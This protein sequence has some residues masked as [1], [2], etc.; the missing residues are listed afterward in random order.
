[1][2]SCMPNT[3]AANQ[4][5]PWLVVLIFNKKFGLKSGTGSGVHWG[6]ENKPGCCDPHE[7]WFQSQPSCSEL[8]CLASH[9]GVHLCLS[10]FRVSGSPGQSVAKARLKRL[11]FLPLSSNLHIHYKDFFAGQIQ[12][13]AVWG[14]RWHAPAPLLTGK[15]ISLAAFRALA[16]VNPTNACWS[17]RYI[18]C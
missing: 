11:F 12:L 16:T 6:R 4:L 8:A 3:D 18:S 17:L 5:Q 1:M 10:A 14:S 7:F 13:E 15:L 9:P 2:V